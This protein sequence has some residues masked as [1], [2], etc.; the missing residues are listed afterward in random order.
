MVNL[1]G[2]KHTA[3]YAI[4]AAVGMIAITLLVVLCAL[5]SIEWSQL[6]HR[7][8]HLNHRPLATW[9][10]FVSIVLALSGVEAIANL[11]GVM[12]KPVYATAKKSIWTVA[13]EVAIFNILLALVML[14]ISP[15]DRDAHFNDML[16]YLSGSYLGHWAELG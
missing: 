9:E 6:P 1:L 16:A 15:L 7:F 14:A 2:P 3:G 13:S 5:P 10:A 12:K 8:G 4:F 11:T